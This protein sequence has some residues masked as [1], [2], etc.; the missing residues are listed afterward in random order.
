MPLATPATDAIQFD[1][2]IQNLASSS[3]ADRIIIDVRE[4]S[5]VK[6][7]GRIPGAQN[8]PITSSPDALFLPAEDFE[9]R[10][11]FPKPSAT[12]EVVFYCKAGVRS[13]TAAGLARMAGWEKVGEYPG[14]WNE[15]EQKGG[16]VEGP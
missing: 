15:W 11:G 4:P 8:V 10:F 1:K 12:D 2:Q 3:S 6:A 5:E 14:S 16:K 7:T 9:D 13:R